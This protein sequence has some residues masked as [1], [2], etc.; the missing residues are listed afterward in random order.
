ME[1][2]GALHEQE[3]ALLEQIRSDLAEG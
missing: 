3:L 2:D 1:A